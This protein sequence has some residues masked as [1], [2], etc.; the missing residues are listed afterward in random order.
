MGLFD[1]IF[2]R[3]VKT[4][5]DFYVLDYSEDG[6]VV[7]AVRRLLDRPGVRVTSFLNSGKIQ[8]DY[9]KSS[10]KMLELMKR[11]DR[12]G[13]TTC[14]EEEIKEAEMFI[15]LLKSGELKVFSLSHEIDTDVV[16]KDEKNDVRVKWGNIQGE[17][18]KKAIAQH[19]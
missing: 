1:F 11:K 4:Y 7:A 16:S 12:Y 18:N 6:E 9:I 2:W 3:G 10:E 14:S 17:F 5:N 15:E 19:K 13:K 8:A